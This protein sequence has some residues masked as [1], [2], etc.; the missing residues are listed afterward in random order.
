MKRIIV[1][2]SVFTLIACSKN[3]K[4]KKAIENFIQTDKKGNKYDLDIKFDKLEISNVTVEDSILLLQE[5]FEKEKEKKLSSLNKMKS[6]FEDRVKEYSEKKTFG[7]DYFLNKA[8]EDLSKQIEEIEETKKW[9]PE[10]LSKYEN[11]DSSEILCKKANT[12][13]R[14][15]NPRLK[16]EQTVHAN[17]FL[18]KDGEPCFKMIRIKED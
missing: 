12:I 9:K 10:Y 7:S 15:E 6:L 4:E 1:L 2:L 8:K 14:F 13:V 17:F 16:V 5:K 18:D 11:R 3:S